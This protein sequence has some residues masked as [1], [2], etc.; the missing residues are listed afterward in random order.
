[1]RGG[2][3]GSP[4]TVAVPCPLESLL[5]GEGAQS[6]GREA[7]GEEVALV[8]GLVLLRWQTG[9]RGLIGIAAGRDD[10]TR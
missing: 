1:M 4:G 9:M 10:E 8:E 2:R 7:V 5:R 6:H 3:G